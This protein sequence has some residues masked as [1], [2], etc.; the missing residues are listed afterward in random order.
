MKATYIFAGQGSQ[1]IGM[2]K[3]FYECSQSAKLMFEEASDVLKIDMKNLLFN[4]NDNLDQTEFSQPA[5]LLMSAIAYTLFETKPLPIFSLG[6]SLGEITANYSVG[7]LDFESALKLVHQRG[8]L[9]KKACEGKQVG[10]MAVLGLEKENLQT[11]C[12]EFN[13]SVWIANI[14]NSSQIVLAGIKQELEKFEQVLKQNG[15]KK[16]LLLPMSVAS[17]CPILE[18]ITNDFGQLLKSFLKDDFTNPIISN[19]TAQPYQDKNEAIELLKNQLISPVQ[20]AKSIEQASLQSEI[21]I[22]FGS[23]ILKGLNKKITE[24]KT[25]SITDMK[26]LEE[27]LK[28]MS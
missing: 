18:S 7:S 3:D 15:V 24:V 25:I 28:E 2:G 21:F 13:S 6:H 14:N 4:E 12:E 10:M 27:A 19:V 26:S 23:S 16:V 17:H 11:L 9:M 22:E 1:K 8:Q 5:I 20:Y